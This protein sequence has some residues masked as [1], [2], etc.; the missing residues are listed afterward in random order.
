MALSPSTDDSDTGPAPGSFSTNSGDLI[1]QTT[2]PLILGDSYQHEVLRHAILQLYL[3]G[4]TRDAMGKKLNIP[5]KHLRRHLEAIRASVLTYMEENPE[6]FGGPLEALYFQVLR[7]RER[8]SALWE[9]L[10]S[11]SQ[12]ME[13]V[14]P[15]FYRLIADEDKAIEGLLGLD[16]KTV[17]LVVGT[18][19]EQA[20]AD[21]LRTMGPEKLKEL[22]VE[23][24]ETHTLLSQ[25]RDSNYGCSAD[26]NAPIIIE[27][28][29]AVTTEGPS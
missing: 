20:Q 22:L 25:G 5:R 9:E 14:R 4:Y 11:E 1:P 8:Q 18:P 29:S 3:R 21:L 12:R 17:S 15:Q 27:G 6:I 23:L 28:T 16:H 10:D 24:R 2:P 26:P 7:R 13:S 19:I